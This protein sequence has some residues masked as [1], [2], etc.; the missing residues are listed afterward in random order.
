[1]NRK[2]NKRTLVKLKFSV[3]N[4]RELKYIKKWSLSE[5]AQNFFHFVENFGE[6]EN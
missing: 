4:F 5:T 2:D 6:C 3:K 1:M